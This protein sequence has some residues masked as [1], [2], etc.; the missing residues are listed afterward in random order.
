MVELQVRIVYRLGKR[1][2]RFSAIFVASFE[3]CR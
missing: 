2:V 3:D 1:L